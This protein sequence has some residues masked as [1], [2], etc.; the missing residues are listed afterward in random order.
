MRLVFIPAR[1]MHPDVIRTDG[2]CS[3]EESGGFEC[4]ATK[5]VPHIAGAT[6]RRE[7][8]WQDRQRRR[9]HEKEPGEG[10]VSRQSEP[11]PGCG[12]DDWSRSAFVEDTDGLSPA[13]SSSRGSRRG[14]K[15]L[16]SSSAKAQEIRLS[17]GTSGR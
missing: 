16:K 10:K 11:R 15:A 12:S 3:A 8:K 17:P 1:R 4:S 5:A 13:R 2:S 7:E 6:G 9:V 14:E